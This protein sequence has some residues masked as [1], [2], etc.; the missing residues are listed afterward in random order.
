MEQANAEE[1]HSDLMAMADELL[2]YAGRSW[3]VL[4]D[5]KAQNKRILFEGAQGIMLDIDH[6]TYPF[7][8]SSNTVATVFDEVTNGYVPWSISSIIPCAPSNKIRLFC[9]LA[10]P[11]TCQLRPA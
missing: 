6:G 1:M 8:T 2:S 10:S 9:A 5:A 11:S 3:Q 4:G 7:V